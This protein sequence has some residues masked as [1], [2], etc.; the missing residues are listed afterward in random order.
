MARS[1]ASHLTLAF[2]SDEIGRSLLHLAMK[3]LMFGGSGS[4]LWVGSHNPIGL[5]QLCHQTDTT[6]SFS[7]GWAPLLFG[8]VGTLKG[9]PPFVG[10]LLSRHSAMFSCR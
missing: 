7:Q 4:C 1:G 5:E 3:A 8:I 10:F 9:T 2:W 6:W